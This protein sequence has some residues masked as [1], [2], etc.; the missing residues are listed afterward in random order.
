MPHYFAM[1]IISPNRK[2]IIIVPHKI[3]T[4]H[5]ELYVNRREEYIFGASS[6]I[7]SVG[8]HPGELIPP[9]PS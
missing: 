7:Y 5:Y 9:N 2:N 4:Y 1:N 8:M 3:N 6:D